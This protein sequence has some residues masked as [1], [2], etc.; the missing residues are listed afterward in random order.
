MSTW[1][2]Q[3]ACM[4]YVSIPHLSATGKTVYPRLPLYERTRYPQSRR[5]GAQT[6][7]APVVSLSSQV[8]E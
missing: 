1:F 3:L 2:S 7:K 6:D 8:V 5:L 4:E